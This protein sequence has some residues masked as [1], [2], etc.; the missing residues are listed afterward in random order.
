[1]NTNFEKRQKDDK[2]LAYEPIET[3]NTDPYIMFKKSVVGQQ[4]DQIDLKIE[5]EQIIKPDNLL[6]NRAIKIFSK[7]I[8]NLRVYKYNSNGDP[9]L[10]IGPHWPFYVCLSITLFFIFFM[11][12]YHLWGYL[13]T[14]IKLG[15]LV[16]YILQ[17]ISYTWVFLIN[18]GIPKNF[19][20]SKI[21][22]SPDKIDKGYKYCNRCKIILSNMVKSNHCNDCDVCI[23][24]NYYF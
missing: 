15:G 21:S 7:R 5:K 12:F 1:M 8:G 10:V 14:P 23:M 2:F 4:M 6:N 9:L 18:P 13:S 20:K 24:G 17:F 11:F 22:D 16:V 19:F 3:S